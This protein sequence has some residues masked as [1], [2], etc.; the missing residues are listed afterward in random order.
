MKTAEKTAFWKQFDSSGESIRLF[1]RDR[2]GVAIPAEKK[3]GT[4]VDVKIADILEN[5]LTYKSLKKE[6]VQKR[7][8]EFLLSPEFQRAKGAVG[9]R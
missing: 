1:Y 5:R 3:D 4:F 9:G 2:S 8:G 6:Q 7:A